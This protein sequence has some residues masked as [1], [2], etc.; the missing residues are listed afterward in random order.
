MEVKIITGTVEEI[1]ALVTATR[2]RREGTF[3]GKRLAEAVIQEMEK[4]RQGE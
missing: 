1:A 3:N 4:S 2:G